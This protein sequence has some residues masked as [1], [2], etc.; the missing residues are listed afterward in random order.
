MANKD[1]KSSFIT[2]AREVHGDKYDYDK[3]VYVKSI[4]PV[5]ITCPEHGDFMQRPDVHL[6]GHGCPACK[7]LKRMDKEEFVRRSNEIHHNKY[8]YSLVEFKG[9]KTK[10]QIICPEHGPFWQLPKNHL[11]GQGC[12]ECGKR[13]AQEWQ[14]NNPQSFLKASKDRF[15]DSYEF[16]FIDSEYENY[17]S[18]ITVKC[19]KCG[20][21]FKKIASYHL[22]LPFGG[23]RYCYSSQ[24]RG[25]RELV[26]FITNLL[27][28]NI[29]VSL[30]DRRFLSGMELD[31]L[32]P[33]LNIAFEYNGCYWHSEEQHHDKYYHLNKTEKCEK[34]GLRLIH[35]FEDELLLKRELVFG[36][37]KHLLHLDTD[38][39]SV[40]ARRCSVRTI[41]YVI[42]A[43]F[44]NRY[45]IQGADKATIY[46]GLYYDDKLVAVMSF[47]IDGDS[48]WILSRYATNSMYNVVG[49]AGKLFSHF[50]KEKNPEEVKSFADRR[51][52]TTLFP[53]MYD[54]L[55]FQLEK[56]TRPDYRY[57]LPKSPIRHHK[58]NFRKANL[59]K[60]YG[61]SDQMTETDM[62]RELKA[63][64]VW[65]AGLLKY[66]W[67]NDNKH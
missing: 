51:W 39:E 8:D 21:S 3:V 61:F 7:G 58:F 5:C 42:G 17:H 54:K 45:H 38:R 41:K 15:N 28:Q 25:E 12:P 19:K 47:I 63:L 48:K 60:K 35:I 13:Y 20:H 31:V 1:L 50:V 33:S 34:Q 2:R 14:K 9:T 26:N 24:S 22:A 44:L 11:K 16:P 62:V 27:P 30:N 56:A 66:V 32:I 65:D 46:Y 23:C 36:K 64:K 4:L 40:F 29:A 43:D 67:Y 55:G 57:I 10:V 59:I 37:I 6:R 53:N 49:G 18:L 52:S